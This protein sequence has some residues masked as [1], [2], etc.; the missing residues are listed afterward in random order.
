M[1]VRVCV[2]VVFG[3]KKVPG[4][5]RK[6]GNCQRLQGPPSKSYKTPRYSDEFIQTKE[7]G[8]LPSGSRSSLELVTWLGWASKPPTLSLSQ[9]LLDLGAGLMVP[10]VLYPVFHQLPV[11]L[12][13]HLLTLQNWG[14]GSTRSPPEAPGP[15]RR[16][17]HKRKALTVLTPHPELYLVWAKKRRSDQKWLSG[18]LSFLRNIPAWFSGL[19]LCIFHLL[20]PALGLHWAHPSVIQGG[21]RKWN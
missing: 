6:K 15:Q 7:I 9:C 20:S 8:S 10:F 19:F 11:D 4:S 21:L 13:L 1:C 16:T 2:T 12:T 14:Q 17:C 18:R 5:L 3:E